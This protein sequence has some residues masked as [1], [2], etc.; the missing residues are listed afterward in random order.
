MQKF[1]V[2]SQY[3]FLKSILQRGWLRRLVHIRRGLIFILMF[4]VSI[5]LVKKYGFSIATVRGNSMSPTFNSGD[6]VVV[7]KWKRWPTAGDIVAIKHPEFD[8][9]LIKRL[10]AKGPAKVFVEDSTLFTDSIPF[11][12]SNIHPPVWNRD[13]FYCEYSPVFVVA[14]D[15][16]FVLGDNRCYSEDSR[17]LGS[18][19]QKA[20]EGTIIMRVFSVEI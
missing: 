4:L 19:Q 17:S 11:Q 8:V 2:R 13:L 12:E 15:S 9:V 20:I 1:S 18:F 5:T 10:I 16:Y 14:P 6:I 7:A 3:L